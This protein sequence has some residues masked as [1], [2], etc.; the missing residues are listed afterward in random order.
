[1]KINKSVEDAVNRA[2]KDILDNFVNYKFN[3]YILDKNI[4]SFEHNLLNPDRLKIYPN[5]KVGT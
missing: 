1:M 5:S 3:S 4:L 2:V